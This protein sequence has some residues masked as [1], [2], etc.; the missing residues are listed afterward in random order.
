MEIPR[1]IGG[2]RISK[3]IYRLREY[4]EAFD[5]LARSYILQRAMAKKI[6]AV[7]KDIDSNI[8]IPSSEDGTSIRPSTQD[9]LHKLYRIQ[10]NS[11][12]EPSGKSR[13]GQQSELELD[14]TEASFD[15]LNSVGIN[16]QDEEARSLMLKDV[17][18]RKAVGIDNIGR[19]KGLQNAA[20]KRIAAHVHFNSKQEVFDTFAKAS[21]IFLSNIVTNI[22]RVSR[23]K[24][25][26]N[27]H[28]FS[29]KY[30][31]AKPREEVRAINIRNSLELSKR[32]DRERNE[33]LKMNE[34]TGKGKQ[35][36]QSA[37][38]QHR[39][40]QA[41][42]EEEERIQTVAANQAA[43]T[44]LGHDGKYLK[45]SHQNVSKAKS[46]VNLRLNSTE[47]IDHKLLRSKHIHHSSC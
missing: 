29:L 16:A 15:V 42:E 41:K 37:K 36:N 5:E 38:L 47:K 14:V 17:I 7:F 2:F 4:D 35:E 11:Y 18:N 22:I 21:E 20:A 24:N 33:L 40:A 10:E 12:R 6:S 43:R 46:A 23:R 32:K 26:S 27:L 25:D 31:T 1:N 45:W 3:L 34:N 8:L 30:V 39:A 9:V 44:A 28:G 13:N 19:N